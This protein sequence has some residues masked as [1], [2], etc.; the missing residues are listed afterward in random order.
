MPSTFTTLPELWPLQP[1]EQPT[2]AAEAAFAAL[3]IAAAASDDA[4]GPLAQLGAAPDV[5][6]EAIALGIQL[7]NLLTQAAAVAD[8]LVA[9]T[10]EAG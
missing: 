10:G 8:Q 7:R 9:V 2:P 4:E 6:P 3:E 5:T 1:G